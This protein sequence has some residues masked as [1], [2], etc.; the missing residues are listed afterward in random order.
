MYV[1]TTGGHILRCIMFG[2]NN[3][4]AVFLNTTGLASLKIGNNNGN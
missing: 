2:T 4:S 3:E 1:D